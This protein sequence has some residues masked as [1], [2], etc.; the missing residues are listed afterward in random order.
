[1]RDSE[2]ADRST[3]ESRGPVRTWLAGSYGS[4]IA[5]TFLCSLLATLLLQ[6]PVWFGLGVR[7]VTRPG[8]IVLSAVLLTVVM[9]GIV[10]VVAS[11]RWP[12]TVMMILAVFIAMASWQRV[13]VLQQPAVPADMRFLSDPALLAA[14]G[15]PRVVVGS[16]VV[17]AV[18]AVAVGWVVDRMTRGWKR[19]AATDRKWVTV[20]VVCVLAA[21]SVLF[22]ASGFN[23]TG[24]VLRR[25]YD[26]VGAQWAAWSDFDNYR[27]NGAVAGALYTLPVEAMEPPAGYDAQTMADVASRWA[28]PSTGEGVLDDTNVVVILSES[29]GELDGVKGVDIQPDPLTNIHA[30][31]RR[32]WGGQTVTDYG[33]G[34]AT[35]E[36]QALTGQ[37]MGLFAPQVDSPFV[38]FVPEQ[39]TYPSVAAWLATRGHRTV[40]VHGFTDE[41]YRRP[42]AY[43]ALGFDE[44]KTR[45]TFGDAE[46]VGLL[47][48]VTDQALFE[49]VVTEI[50][51]SEAPT[52]VH[53]VTMQN[54]GPYS[55]DTFGT[56]D[57]TLA[58]PNSGAEAK[59]GAWA[60]GV[61]DSDRAV[62]ELMDDLE[63]TG[64]PT[65]LVYF[66][67]H[68][69]GVLPSG[70][71][72]ADPQAARRAP[73]FVW[74]SERVDAARDPLG[75]VAASSFIEVAAE[76]HGGEAPGYLRLLRAVR[77]Q[78]GA[79]TVTGAVRPDGSAL[80]YDDMTSEQRRLVDDLRLVQYDFSV[81]ERYALADLWY[82]PEAVDAR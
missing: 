67:D 17:V 40:A 69:P 30:Q 9:M 54:H 58:A 38:Q 2:G 75:T 27:L 61:A 52:L 5:T 63:Q 64:E 7:L 78:V 10:S 57:V 70:V 21:M 79:L 14:L 59:I 66:G 51:G 11:L 22:A 65:L 37:S 50:E 35:M 49:E 82:E 45:E 72:S 80:S 41:L 77:E 3:Q 23:R 73:F 47:G 29:M 33:T 62:R 34:T 48:G 39:G 68:F 24:N 42:E 60:A 13:Q 12:L 25:S 36:F 31:I 6:L 76:L 20:R 32:G 44:F 81:G 28:A 15:S 19:P 16:L 8:P 26:A 74:D 71:V 56:A 46:R 4:A 55:A 1:M 43:R 53:V 18:A